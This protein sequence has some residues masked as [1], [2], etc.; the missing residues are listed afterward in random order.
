MAQFST[1]TDICGKSLGCG[2]KAYICNYSSGG[3]NK[4]SIST[5]RIEE[6]IL[7]LVDALIKA[8]DFK[9]PTPTAQTPDELT[10]SKRKRLQKNYDD[11]FDLF[12]QGIIDREQLA[13]AKRKLQEQ[14]D[15]LEP[16]PKK[17]AAVEAESAELTSLISRWDSAGPPERRI[18][19][20]SLID[21]IV[22]TAP[23]PVRAKANGARFDFER[24]DIQ[25]AK[26]DENGNRIPPTPLSPADSASSQARMRK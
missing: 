11:S 4:M 15:R 26:W 13:T 23:D 24:A 25:W 5:A 19:I 21:R 18:V 3:C 20:K 16:K 7:S 10:E 14:L 1:V 8:K 22:I 2:A 9:L 12:M 17:A 6:H